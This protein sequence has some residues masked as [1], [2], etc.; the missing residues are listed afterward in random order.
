MLHK[1]TSVPLGPW[2]VP[3]VTLENVKTT[4]Q[5]CVPTR[6]NARDTK[7][8][9]QVLK[10]MQQV[11]ACFTACPTTLYIREVLRS[12]QIIIESNVLM[13]P[14]IPTYRYGLHTTGIQWALSEGA[15]GRFRL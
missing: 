9:S 10:M 4:A 7:C 15:L 14:L 13:V 3:L 6:V 8:A 11:F 1:T 2:L 5:S 12:Y